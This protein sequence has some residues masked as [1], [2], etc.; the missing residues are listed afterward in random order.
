[1]K[2]SKQSFIVKFKEIIK[3]VTV[4][5]EWPRYLMKTK[6]FMEKLK[7]MLVQ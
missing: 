3:N 5:R 4:D 1:M 7:N 2:F 6:R